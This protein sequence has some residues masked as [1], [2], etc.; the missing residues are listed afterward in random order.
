MVIPDTRAAV[1]QRSK[2][3]PKLRGSIGVPLSRAA[4][5]GRAV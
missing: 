5:E 4:V 1:M 3:R 2:L